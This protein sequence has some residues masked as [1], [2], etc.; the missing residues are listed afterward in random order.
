[1]GADG[2]LPFLGACLAGLEGC[3]VVAME[4]IESCPTALTGCYTVGNIQ[5]SGID[6]LSSHPHPQ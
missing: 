3:D 2:R 5:V 4:S 1:M 6:P